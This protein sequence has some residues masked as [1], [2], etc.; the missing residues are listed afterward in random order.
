MFGKAHLPLET[1]C[2]LGCRSITFFWKFLFHAM[3]LNTNNVWG[4]IKFV[5]I[6][7]R[8]YMRYVVCMRLHVKCHRHSKHV[9]AANI[10]YVCH[11]SFQ[12]LHSAMYELCQNTAF[13][14]TSLPSMYVFCTTVNVA[15]LHHETI[16]NRWGSLPFHLLS[17]SS[18]EVLE[19][20][21]DA[22]LYAESVADSG[23]QY[24]VISCQ[25]MQIYY[26]CHEY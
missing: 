21:L 19:R 17:R 24:P 8:N 22:R 3:S 16:H 9:Y 14:Y 11:V 18:S 4:N 15:T 2:S 23:I 7:E 12:T 13:V 1:I 6:L 10:R 25:A 5:S 20:V 26:Y